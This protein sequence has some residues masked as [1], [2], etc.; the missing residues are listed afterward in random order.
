MAVYIRV[1]KELAHELLS[2]GIAHTIHLQG[3]SY[4]AYYLRVSDFYMVCSAED[5]G[6]II[7]DN[8]ARQALLITSSEARITYVEANHIK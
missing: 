8:L 1:S 4:K 7:A 2:S 5:A 6:W 3:L